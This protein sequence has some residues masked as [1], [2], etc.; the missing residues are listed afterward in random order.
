[1]ANSRRARRVLLAGA[2]EALDRAAVVRAADPAIAGAELE[3]GHCRFALT[4][5][6]VANRTLVSTPLRTASAR[7][8]SHASTILPLQVT[9]GDDPACLRRR[10]GRLRHQAQ[11][12]EQR[13]LVVVQVPTDDPPARS[14]SA[15]SRTAAARTPCGGGEWS[16]R[17]VV[18]T[19]DGKGAHHRLASVDVAGVGDSDVRGGLDPPCQ[20]HVLELLGCSECQASVLDPSN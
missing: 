5:S 3:S 10:A 6:R 4:A 17:P 2:V 9:P 1:M 15:T 20:E 11:L 12:H 13:D 8:V 16:E 19:D 18:R 7:H 14:R